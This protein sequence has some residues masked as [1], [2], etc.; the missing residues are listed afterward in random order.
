MHTTNKY[1]IIRLQ[2]GVSD[3]RH[4]FRPKKLTS[5]E[6]IKQKNIEK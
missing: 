5:V 3:S 2:E 1:Y 4:A 6:S